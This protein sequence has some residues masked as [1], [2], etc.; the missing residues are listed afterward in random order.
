MAEKY[1]QNHPP[2]YNEALQHPV[3]GQQQQHQQQQY[4]QSPQ[5]YHHQQH[6]QYG[7]YPQHY[8]QQHQQPGPYPQHYLQQQQHHQQQYGQ[9]PQHYQQQQRPPLHV[10]VEEGQ[11]D[12]GARFTSYAPKSIPPPPPGVQP[13]MAQLKAMGAVPQDQ[14]AEMPKQ[15][16][17]GFWSGSGT[18]GVSFW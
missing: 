12:A 8:Q 6:Q 1:P 13:N 17:G 14:K 3:V 9:Y 4:G 5:H 10:P 16:K 2:S 11:F 18:G 7:Q 15:K